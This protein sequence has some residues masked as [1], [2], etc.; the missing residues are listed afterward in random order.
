MTDPDDVIQWSYDVSAILSDSQDYPTA[1]KT[2][3]WRYRH[4]F[5]KVTLY[6]TP[7][8]IIPD[9]KFYS[10]GRMLFFD[11]N[12]TYELEARPDSVLVSV[13]LNINCILPVVGRLIERY[14]LQRITKEQVRQTLNRL[15]KFCEGGGII[16]D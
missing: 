11:W 16:N 3:R 1:Q 7:M 4:P 6:D 8:V 14:Y 13:A 2:Y 9:Q 5:L 12:E 15:S 10:V